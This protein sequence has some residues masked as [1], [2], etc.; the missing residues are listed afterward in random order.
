M[1]RLTASGKVLVIAEPLHFDTAVVQYQSLIYIE[2]RLSETKGLVFII[3]G[4]AISTNNARFQSV[5][6]W[7]GDIP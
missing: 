3:N 5:E 1:H 4:M 2:H 7:L 6:G